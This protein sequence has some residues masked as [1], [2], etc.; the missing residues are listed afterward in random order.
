[1]RLRPAHSRRP[2]S[3]RHRSSPLPSPAR[4][5]PHVRRPAIFVIILIV[6]LVVYW[7]LLH[8]SHVQMRDRARA[9]ALRLASQTGHALSLHFE[10]TASKLDH[11]TRQLGWQW[12]QDSRPNFDNAVDVTMASLPSGALTQV[13]VADTRGVIQYSR[14]AGKPAVF[15]PEPPVSIFDREHFQVH[16]KVDRP[17]MFISEP[18]KGRISQRWTIQ[19]TRGLWKDGTFAG[20][21]VLSVSAD[22]LASALTAIFPD[23]TD[24]GSL[25]NSSGAYLARSYHLSEVLGYAL[26]ATR[27]F[28]QHPELDSGTYESFSD[29]DRIKRLYSWHRVAGYPLIVIVGQGSEKALALT[30]QA[31]SDSHWQSGF[32]SGFL[33]LIGLIV[34]WLWA[35]GSWRAS[36]AQEVNERLEL[37]VRGGNL[38][39]WEC[40]LRDGRLSVNG[41]FTTI[42]EQ[43][44]AIAPQSLAA[45]EAL[46]HPHDRQRFID[47]FKECAA[48]HTAELA[49]EYRMLGADERSIHVAVHGRIA[50]LDAQG[51]ASRIAGTIQDVSALSI[52]T[53]RLTAL[54]QN[55]PG[56]VLIEDAD[57]KVAFVNSL[58]PRLLR[59]NM[60]PSQLLGLSDAELKAR[61]GTTISGWLSTHLPEPDCE[62]RQRHEI[63]TEN[64]QYLEIEHVKIHQNGE[65]L[66][67]LWLV[68][69]ITERKQR[70]IDLALLAST[71]AL[72]HLPNRRSFMQN[73]QLQ[74][75][76][77]QLSGQDVG[78][79]MMLDIDHFK[80]VNDTYG[81][82]VGDVVL[83]NIAR[84]M[85]DTVR[86]T[87]TPGRLG[88]EEFAVL[89][90]R[91]EP[92]TGMEI[93]ERIRKRIEAAETHA[94]GHVIRVT[95]SIGVAKVKADSPP[96]LTL[97]Q[98]DEAL[99]R[100][101]QT[102][103]NRVCQF[104]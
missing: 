19:F 41:I 94:D 69:D 72:T 53:S 62:M 4:L 27:P 6:S 26:P 29:V 18:V 82:A 77:A 40:R 95:I 101:K 75:E 21:I 49:G 102:G 52:E 63:M 56:G 100:A 89:L 91:A 86:T 76:R 9:D 99:Y 36:L 98:A 2:K 14:L 73:M 8:G 51:N 59:L 25:L 84:I 44:P 37:A 83:Q 30:N 66:G 93:A 43:D 46:V 34:A 54:L 39:A 78:M 85:R 64:G 38:G 45:W 70:E 23:A 24:A 55:F 7:V 71:D 48:I 42:L 87:D 92:V 20:V 17:F 31:I 35:K 50:E 22:H 104:E 16:L 5:W 13:A 97:K 28:I 88:G 12:T 32:G 61:L 57:D 74:H 68:H 103:R 58:W 65:S 3:L 15:D 1:M 90:P 11:F 81:H 60:Q 10:T 67:S 47:D 33:L 79:V 96:D 80:K